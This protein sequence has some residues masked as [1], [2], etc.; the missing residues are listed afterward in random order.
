MLGPQKDVGVNEDSALGI[1]HRLA[2][3]RALLS[4]SYW[5]SL[6]CSDNGVCGQLHGWASS[7]GWARVRVL[8]VSGLALWSVYGPCLRG[9]RCG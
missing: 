3:H 2:Y 9:L 6:G 8:A 4:A 1:Y 5:W 7:E